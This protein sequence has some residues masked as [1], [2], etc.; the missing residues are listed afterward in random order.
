MKL[1]RIYE[2]CQEI[3][4]DILGI[5][6]HEILMMMDKCKTQAEFEVIVNEIWFNPEYSVALKKVV[7]YVF[8]KVI[9][10]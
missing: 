9:N 8:H 1:G 10:K 5:N 2:A 6:L 3:K 7:A 4:E